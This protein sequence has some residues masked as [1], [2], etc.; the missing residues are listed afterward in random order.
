M[1]NFDFDYWKSLAERDPAEFFRVRDEALR[2]CIALY[3][4]QQALLVAF[5]ARIDATRVLAGS[6]LQASRALFALMED[7]LLLLNLKLGELQRETDSLRILL[8]SSH[9]V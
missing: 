7:Q 3:P 8:G 2:Q 9:T 6:P 1:G 5:Q 4:D